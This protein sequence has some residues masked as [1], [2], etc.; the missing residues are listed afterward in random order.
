MKIE[1]AIQRPAVIIVF[2]C[3]IGPIKKKV[4]HEANKQTESHQSVSPG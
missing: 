1:L 4:L 2:S 3:C